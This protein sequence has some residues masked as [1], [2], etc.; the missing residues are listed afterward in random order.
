MKLFW[1]IFFSIM[2]ISTLCVSVGGC[3][4]VH[5]NFQSLLQNE[6]STAYELGDIA[7]FSLTKELLDKPSGSR[8]DL[9]D[10]TA[11]QEIKLI[12]NS[13]SI[14]NTGGKIR[15]A[16]LNA[17]KETLF[18]SL[19]NNFGKAPFVNLS[20]N[21]RGYYIQ[22]SKDNYYVQ[23]VRPAQLNGQLCYIETNRDVTFIFENQIEQYKL[24]LSIMAAMLLLVSILSL[25]IS[26]LLIR[27]IVSLNTTV[28]KIAG[29]K[30]D[31]R[32]TESG[33]DE[34][35]MLSQNFNTM[36]NTLENNIHMLREQAEKEE[37]FVAAF[38]HELKTPL[39]S[40][41]G[42]ADTLRRKEMSS[43]RVHLCASYIFTEGKRLEN[44][45]M[46]LLDLIVLKNQELHRTP[47]DIELFLNEIK[48]AIEPQ[49]L[50]ASI[51]LKISLAPCTVNF[52][53]DLMKNVF[54][55]LL[56]NARKAL[57]DKTDGQITI[58][59]FHTL[60]GYVIDICD[61]GNGIAPHDLARIKE[62]FYM[63]DKSRSRKQGGAGLG[64]S[65]CEQIVRLHGYEMIISS[66]PNTG[67][68]VRLVLKGEG[69]DE[70]ETI[71]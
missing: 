4:L 64:L 65:I 16:I 10:E 37:Q 48:D 52:E 17:E 28:M 43:E 39:T 12:A 32:V 25:I 30:I 15:F 20:T 5:S 6:V 67:T 3:I 23:A 44:L 14:Q 34:V 9:S 21:E 55:N 24:L 61:N 2:Y 47:V 51:K 46:R 33:T 60:A 49:L 53:D 57:S 19:E 18:S 54:L 35:A 66:E 11:I 56:D 36:A 22:G 45:S 40:I 38:S 63:A 71:C 58:T 68:S 13:I 69:G 1:K 8:M 59:G 26:K 27:R 42:Y 7:Y 41:I 62:A 50:Q 31:E 29:G 70:N